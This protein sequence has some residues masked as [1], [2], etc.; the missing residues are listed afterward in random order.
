MANKLDNLKKGKDTRFSGEQAVKA[1]KKGAVKS[2]A[3]RRT[4]ADIR[5]MLTAALFDEYT[6]KKTGEKIEGIQGIVRA[7]VL[8]SLSGKDKDQLAAIKYIFNL[9][10]LD[11]TE[12]EAEKDKAEIELIKAR[13]KQMQAG[14][15][16]AAVDDDVRQEVE[17]IISE[18]GDIEKGSAD[19]EAE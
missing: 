12:A 13:I 11:K 3:T 9:L 7:L 4:N 5:K 15:G 1:G 19:N 18:Y 16:S 17:N 6:D 14:Q 8:K 10:G 2:A